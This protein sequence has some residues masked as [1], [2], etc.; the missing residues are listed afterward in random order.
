M[1]AARGALTLYITISTECS[2]L[3]AFQPVF[4]IVDQR[5]AVGVR[6]LA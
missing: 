3:G 4:D 6:S 1:I 5:E 2:V